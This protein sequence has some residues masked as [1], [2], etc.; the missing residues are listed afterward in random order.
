MISRSR[1]TLFSIVIPCVWHHVVF[2]KD[3]KFSSDGVFT[4]DF[5]VTRDLFFTEDFIRHS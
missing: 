2:D 5:L 4:D 3:F 1:A